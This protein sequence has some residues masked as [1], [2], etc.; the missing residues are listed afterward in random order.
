MLLRLTASMPQASDLGHLL[1]KHPDRV[2]RFAT[3]VG[4]ATVLFPECTAE[5][6]TATLVVEVDPV[7]LVRE[8]RHPA[9]DQALAQYVNDRPYAASSLLC[10]AMSRVFGSA[11]A[12]TCPERPE[13]A[14]SAIPLAAELPCLPCRGGEA[15]LRR[16]FEPL[17]YTVTATRS[18]LD[19]RFPDW[20]EGRWWSVR[21]EA[22]VRLRD[23]LHHLYVLI[24]VLDDD[25][26]YWVG[27]DEV[28]KLMAHGSGWLGAHPERALIAE[29]YLKHAPRLTRDALAR[30][31]AADGGSDDDPDAAAASH[32][33]EEAAV[34]R[35]ISLNQ[36]RLEAVLAVLRQHGARRIGDLGC[37]EGR[38]ISRLLEDRSVDRIIGVDASVRA[39][40]IAAQRLR[41]ERMPPAQRARLELV[42]GS[43]V[44]RDQRLAGLD[45]AVS[46]EVIEHL[47]PHR[48]PAYTRILLGE[49]RAPLT[50]VTTPNREHNVRF[51]GLAPGAM[52]HRDHR[53]EWTRAEFRAWAESAAAAHGYAVS[54]APIGDDDPEVGP[55]TQMAVFR[56]GGPEGRGDG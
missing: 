23:L 11:M 13:L 46:V 16:L 6:C 20:G 24:P 38:L 1:R 3:T 55:P 14:A 39:L 36:R 45:A 7:A 35:P 50:V 51:A 54:L 31:A 2:H 5:R 18:L 9:G 44:Y 33:A 40:E 43:L 37:G 21:L 12:G 4:E 25:K 56:R 52:R 27:D 10:V 53:F 28:A 26:H 8:R 22:R 49:V 34:E 15:V 29:R 41:L 32:A 47:D 19:E 30:L 17:G 48:L 42:H